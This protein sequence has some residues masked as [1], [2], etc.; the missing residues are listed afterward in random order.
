MSPKINGA[1]ISEPVIRLDDAADAAAKIVD[2]HT[3][4]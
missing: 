2:K 1:G 3:F 4:V